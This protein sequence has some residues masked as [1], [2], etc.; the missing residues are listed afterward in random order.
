M[1]KVQR[2]LDR[3]TRKGEE[4]YRSAALVAVAAG[5]GLRVGDAVS[6]RW[7]DVLDDSGTVR[8]SV[9]LTEEKTGQHRQVRMF[10]FVGRIL[11]EYK[12]HLG[13]VDLE[14]PIVPVSKVTA[15][16]LVKKAADLAG[17]KGNIST[18]SLRKA[19]CDFAY[20]Q[21]KDPVLTCSITG[22]RNPAHL[23]RYINRERDVVEDVWNRMQA[24]AAKL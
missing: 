1:E 14:A 17:L 9:N 11:S 16:R 20:R 19:F 8:S 5:Y 6:L 23:L 24:A 2:L 13:F 15:W 12:Q 18:H 7:R 21:T 10:P 3:L 4:D 22:H